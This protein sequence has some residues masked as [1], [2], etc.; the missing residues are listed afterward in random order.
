MSRRLFYS[1]ATLIGFT[2]V[3]NLQADDSGLAFSYSEQDPATAVVGIVPGLI[4]WAEIEL[5]EHQGEG[6]YKGLAIDEANTQTMI[7]LAKEFE[8]KGKLLVENG[9]TDKALP[10]F[11]A[12]EAIARYAASMPHLLEDRVL[13]GEEHDES[14][15]DHHK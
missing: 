6:L 5:A 13:G 12:A 11:L 14:D 8:A 7:F 10:Q 2:I 15:E 3:A 9:D 4:I 1:F